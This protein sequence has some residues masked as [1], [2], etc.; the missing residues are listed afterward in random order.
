MKKALAWLRI[1]EK[2]KGITP[3]YFSDLHLTMGVCYMTGVGKQMCRE[4][5]EGEK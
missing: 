1:A 5:I 4:N 2:N 3:E